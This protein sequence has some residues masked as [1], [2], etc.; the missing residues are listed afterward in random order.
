MCYLSSWSCNHCVTVRLLL[1]IFLGARRVK[2]G[3]SCSLWH[4]PYLLSTR[5]IFVQL[6]GCAKNIWRFLEFENQRACYVTRRSVPTPHCS[7]GTVYQ[8]GL[9]RLRGEVSDSGFRDMTLL[10]AILCCSGYQNNVKDK[11]R[12]LNHKDMH[13]WL[14]HM[15]CVRPPYCNVLSVMMAEDVVVTNKV[16]YSNSNDSDEFQWAWNIPGTTMP[17]KV[18]FNDYTRQLHVSALT[19]NRRVFFKRTHGPTIYIC[20]AHTWWRDRKFS[21]RKTDDGWYVPKHV[22]F[23]VIVNKTS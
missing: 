21:W 3:Q 11:W 4:S 22:V 12:L 7:S 1:H 5:L 2:T 8:N 15:V 23:L 19:G 16:S 13:I 9:L 17:I 20:C 18:F 6:G 14:V 10:A